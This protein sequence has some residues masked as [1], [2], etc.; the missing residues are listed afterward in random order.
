[1]DN[2]PLILDL[3]EWIAEEPRQYADVM[4]AW[5]TSCPKLPI[6]E[7]TLDAALVCVRSQ[8]VHIT[9]EGLAFLTQHRSSAL[10]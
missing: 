4:E 2:Q 5:R 8:Q 3:L 6:W 10:G 9:A 1:V 7:D